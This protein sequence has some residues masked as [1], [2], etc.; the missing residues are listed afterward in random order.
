[1]LIIK[2]QKIF[3][4]TN[5]KKTISNDYQEDYFNV[6]NKILWWRIEM[7]KIT[8][9]QKFIIVLILIPF[10]F[11]AQGKKKS[12]K[13][14]QYEFTMIYQVKTTPVKN[15]AKTGTCWSFATTSFIETE[16]IRMGKGEHILSPMWNVRFTYPKKAQNYIRYNG[17]TNFGM[18]GQAHD[19]MNVIR[20]YGL[21]PEEVY[22]GMNINEGEHNHGEM[23]AVLKSIVDAVSKKKGGKITPVWQK[24]IESTLDIYLG[25]PPKEFNYKGKNYTP[26]SFADSLGFNPDDYIELTSFTHHPFYTKFDLEIPDN[27]SKDLY[28]N[29]PID[30]LMKIM[31]YALEHGYSIAWDGD[32][33]EKSFDKKKCIAVIPAD[34]SEESEEE[35]NNSDEDKNAIPVKEK[36]I[37]QEMRQETFDNQTTTDDHLMHIVGLAKDQNGTKFYYTK[38]S[39][40]TKNKKYNGYWYMSESYARL[41]V[42]A[43][44]VHKDAIPQDIKIKLGL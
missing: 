41:K 30:D 26:K 12:D 24:V 8:E 28:Y 37:T 10:V 35:K 23:D 2:N 6:I 11:Y 34:S 42:I 4:N 20:E 21:V 5:Y 18:G 25:V 31:N 19:V 3:V 44:M 22:K 13:K 15:Q 43:I 7:K 32:V 33:S 38:N 29:V 1:L 17:L 39:W 40:G 9:F 16:L 27:W 14:E 36:T